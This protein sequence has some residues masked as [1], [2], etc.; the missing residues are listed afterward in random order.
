MSTTYCTTNYYTIQ[1]L[2]LYKLGRTVYV[3]VFSAMDH[4]K[5]LSG[6]GFK[7]Y[8]Y[9]FRFSIFRRIRQRGCREAANF[10]K[11]EPII[12]FFCD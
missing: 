4:S 5:I 1:Y 2:L 11:Q 8:I 9:R 6:P 3:T 12:I 10:E 7:L